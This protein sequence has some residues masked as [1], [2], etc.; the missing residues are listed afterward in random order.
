MEW[1]T[2][3]RRLEL[4]TL[5]SAAA[6]NAGIIILSM[7]LSSFSACKKPAPQAPPPPTV[8]V[9]TVVPQDVPITKTWVGTL[10]GE[11][12]VSIRAQV[13]GYLLEQVYTNGGFVNKGDVLFQIDERPFKAALDQAQG[14]LAQAEAQ[15]KAALLTAQRSNELY[16]KQVISQEQFDDQTQAYFG[17]KATAES[18]QAA[19]DQANLNLG[20]TRITSPISGLASIATAQVGDLVGPSSEVLASVTQVDPI[21][22]NFSAAEQEYIT[23]VERF[24][25]KPGESPVAQMAAKAESD[26]KKMTLVL[27]L[28]NGAVYPREGQLIAVNNAVTANTGTIELQGSFPNPGNLLRPG[29]FGLVSAIVRTAN[30][31]IVVPQRAVGNLQG[32]SQ[33]GVVGADNKVTIQNITP[34]AQIGSDWI[35]ESGISAGDRIVVEGLQKLKNGMVVNPTPYTLTKQEAVSI[36]DQ[37]PGAASGIPSMTPAAPVAPVPTPPPAESPSPSAPPLETPAPA[38]APTPMFTTPAA[39]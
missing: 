2:N 25:T 10:V 30:N 9:I 31:A 4:V 22:V 16:A 5:R 24:F 1:T 3:S 15:L 7:G 21:K 35:I 29:Q 14:T 27:T 39:N 19:V 18:A 33:M 23:F 28:A 8:E 37:L 12:D 6:R 26:R 38:G 20:F 32:Q 13:S 17:A 34:G 36:K 11:V